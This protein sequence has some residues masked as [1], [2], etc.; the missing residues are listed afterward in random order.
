MINLLFSEE[1]KTQQ[2][3]KNKKTNQATKKVSQKLV[4][5]EYTPYRT[6]VPISYPPTG[7]VLWY[8]DKF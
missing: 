4:K 6:D 5:R 3:K 1:A 8:V 7:P 2:L